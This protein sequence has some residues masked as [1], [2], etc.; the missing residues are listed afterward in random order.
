MRNRAVFG[1]KTGLDV[2]SQGG[3][4]V[5]AGSRTD[6]GEYRWAEDRPVAELPPWV[7]EAAGGA[8]NGPRRETAVLAEDEEADVDR[9]RRW[10]RDMAPPSVEGEGGD[11]NAFRVAC[12]VR[13][14]GLSD[15]ACLEAM[16][17]EWNG[18]CEPPW[19]ADELAKKVANAYEYARAD[20]GSRSPSVDF[21][22][23]PPPEGEMPKWPSNLERLNERYCL[24]RKDG[25]GGYS[26]VYEEERD[27]SGHV[28]WDRMRTSAFR[29]Y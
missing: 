6:A 27:R 1:D 9:A 14:L 8:A 3:Y 18:R 26:W 11:D 7:A 21:E 13:D 4:V 29:D 15:G 16:L 24:V 19:G 25:G 22:G 23:E 20:Q 17:D 5:G 28:R 12:A 2:K 10:L